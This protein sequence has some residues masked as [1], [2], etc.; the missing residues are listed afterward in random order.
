[1]DLGTVSG[2]ASGFRADNGSLRGIP[3]LPPSCVLVLSWWYTTVCTNCCSA[4]WLHREPLALW[5]QGLSDFLTTEMNKWKDLSNVSVDF[6]DHFSTTLQLPVDRYSAEGLIRNSCS[7]SSTCFSLS[8]L[9]W[10]LELTNPQSAPK[11]LLVLSSLLWSDVLSSSF[12]FS[13]VVCFVSVCA[14]FLVCITFPLLAPISVPLGCPVTA[15]SIRSDS[16]S[17]SCLSASPVSPFRPAPVYKP[18]DGCW[19]PLFCCAVLV[20][21]WEVR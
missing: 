7:Q 12:L 13:V 5:G 21:V 14:K 11:L 1:M 3:Q 17:F 18:R 9:F 16:P 8:A 20:P 15:V 10:G 19:R 6:P 2:A 4:A